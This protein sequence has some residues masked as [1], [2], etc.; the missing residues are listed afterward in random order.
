MKRICCAL[1][2][3]GTLAVAAAVSSAA[4][5][6]QP[7]QPPRPARTPAAALAPAADIAIVDIGTT[8]SPGFCPVFT[9]QNTG[10]VAL[11]RHIRFSYKTNGQWVS[12]NGHTFNLAVGEKYIW[13]RECNGPDQRFAQWGYE[14]EVFLDPDNEFAE[15]NESNNYLRKTIPNPLPKKT[16]APR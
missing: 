7:P 2:A 15:S 1:L 13:G 8:G 12:L 6:P 4:P 14:L 9:F 10:K 5:K 11:N 16:P 3:V